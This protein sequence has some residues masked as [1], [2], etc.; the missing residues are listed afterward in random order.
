[1][2]EDL[3]KDSHAII[4]IPDLA[5]L[6]RAHLD[7]LNEW[8]MAGGHLVFSDSLTVQKSQEQTTDTPL[9]RA[10]SAIGFG[11]SSKKSYSQ[12]SIDGE[13]ALEVKVSHRT[14]EKDS[15]WKTARYGE[16]RIS[17]MGVSPLDQESGRVSTEVLA[18]IAGMRLEVRDAGTGCATTLL[19][20]P[21]GAPPGHLQRMATDLKQQGIQLRWWLSPESF[22]RMVPI[23]QNSFRQMGVVFLDDG[24]PETR[25]RAEYLWNK[26]RTHR[27]VELA[28][29]NEVGNGAEQGPKGMLFHALALRSTQEL[30]RWRTSCVLGA[31]D[32]RYLPAKTLFASKESETTWSEALLDDGPRTYTPPSHIARR[33]KVLTTARDSSEGEKTKTLDFSKDFP[34]RL[35]EPSKGVNQ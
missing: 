27:P 5:H 2:A 35:I 23:W 12:I 17:F 25:F 33:A 26:F 9:L 11:H 1:M 3:L 8:V 21:F 16:G 15:W 20:E 31:A 4:L 6:S 32:V 34:T 7:S 13:N 14:L 19:L 28:T 22:A 24:K 30:S 10:A 29:L 18:R